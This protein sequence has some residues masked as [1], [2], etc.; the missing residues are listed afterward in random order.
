MEEETKE[1]EDD[2]KEDVRPPIEPSEEQEVNE[3]IQQVQTATPEKK[4]EE[5]E[6]LEEVVE[7]ISEEKEDELE[8]IQE[9]IR[10]SNVVEEV[11]YTLEPKEEQREVY[12]KKENVEYESA[13][14][15]TIEGEKQYEEVEETHLKQ[16][17]VA[18][19]KVLEDIDP[20]E[21]LK[22][23]ID[24]VP[25]NDYLKSMREKK[26]KQEK[27]IAQERYEEMTGTNGDYKGNGQ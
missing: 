2:S 23:R 19:R 10:G 25:E 1:V 20:K 15:E 24:V 27:E 7:E 9:Q 18:V 11:K 12:Q 14:A 21:V 22:K 26:E 3:Q 13:P 4:E 6:A 8:K 16:D 17:S 5:P